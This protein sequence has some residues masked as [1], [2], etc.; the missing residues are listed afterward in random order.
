MNVEDGIVIYMAGSREAGDE[1]DESDATF[2]HFFPLL[3]LSVFLPLTLTT[4][5]KRVK[6]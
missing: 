4:L 6:L 3:L 1:D 5:C 2:G